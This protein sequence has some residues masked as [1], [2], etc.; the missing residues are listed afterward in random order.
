MDATGAENHTTILVIEPSSLERNMLW[1]GTDDGKVHYTTNGGDSWNDVTK[2]IKGLPTG[3]WIA[4]IKASNKNKGEALL[5]AN[6]YRRFNYTP[7][8]Y[9]TKDYGKTWTRIVDS[10]DV[11]SYTLSIVEDPVEKNL[12]FLGTDDGLYISFDAGNKWTK[13]KNGFPTVSVKDLVIHE[14]EHDLIIGTFGRAAWVLDDIRPLR[15]LAKNKQVINQKLELFEPPVA[16][17]AAYQQPTGS[18]FGAD[19]MYHG[20]NRGYGA[21]LS[22]FVKIDE[23]KKDP[24]A[25]KKKKDKKED[26]DTISEEKETKVKWDSIHLKIYD[27]DRLIRTQKRKAPDS[28]GLYKWTWFMDEAGVDFPSK[29]IRKRNNEPGGVSVKPGRYKAV[30]S[31]G[32]QTSEEMIQV[33]LDPRVKASMASINQVYDTSKQLESMQQ[34]TADAV[35]QLIESKTI[36]KDYQSLLSK[37]DKDKYKDDIK[38]SKAIVKSIDSIVDK[39]LGKDDKRQGITRS[40]E[41]T[42]MQRLRSARGYVGSRQNGITSTETTLIKHASDAI[43]EV[44]NEINT[45]FSDT[46]APYRSKMEQVQ[47][48]PFKDIKTFKLD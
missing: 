30:M 23:M 6:D 36:A 10:G 7:Y 21:R 9:R 32:D 27:G 5:I 35:K 18:R 37:L 48:N 44:L 15:A 3:S 47:T 34:T 12:M 17:Q 26:S 28:T 39:I 43:E 16:Y 46:W 40:P 4:Q 25:K 19:A 24:E 2:N 22:Y 31:F 20:E 41:I 11:E 14:R 33:K 29:R 8:A 42:V 13:W 45:F 38:S 1:V